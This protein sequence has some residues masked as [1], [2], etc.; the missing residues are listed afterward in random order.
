MPAGRPRQVDPGTL[1]AVAHQLYWDFR[2]LAEGR[3][4][5]FLDRRKRE[6]LNRR[7]E[8]AK[9]QPSRARKA[10]LE[11][12]AEEEIRNGRLNPIE[13][14]QWLRDTEEGE[15]L[16]R[17]VSL[18]QS[19]A[20]RFTKRLKFRAE[21]DVLEALLDPKTSPEQ[22]R[23][24]C[25]DAFM[26]RTFEI[27]PG[28]TKAVEVPAWPISVGS[29]L[30]TYLSQHAEQYVAALQDRRFPRCDVSRRPSNQL[31][32]FWFLSR[33]LAGAICGIKTRTAINLVGS[34]RPEQVFRESRDGKPAR[35]QRKRRHK[36]TVDI[37]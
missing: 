37:K 1:Y 27:E 25:K 8:K 32:Q 12:M 15:R 24:I 7:V 20:E 13:K 10:R 36:L 6:E 21:L 9:L 35:K 17:R 34:M 14:D 4:R 2:R 30:P 33:A 16:A 28:V 19:L 11:Q 3:P 26:T 31:K 18:H 29:T 5:Q 22:V 23:E